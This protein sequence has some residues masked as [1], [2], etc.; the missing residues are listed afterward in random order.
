MTAIQDQLL[1]DARRLVEQF[2]GSRGG[3]EPFALARHVDGSVSAVQPGE[4]PRAGRWSGF[5]KT[6]CGLHTPS[7][8]P[9][10]LVQLAPVGVEE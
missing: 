7:P 3:F 2:V 10:E 9:P 1:I 5:R 4:D 6:E 8:R